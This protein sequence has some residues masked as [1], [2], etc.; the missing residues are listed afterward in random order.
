VN[1]NQAVASFADPD[2]IV[3]LPLI[4]MVQLRGTTYGNSLF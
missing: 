4:L 2:I 1:L 3:H